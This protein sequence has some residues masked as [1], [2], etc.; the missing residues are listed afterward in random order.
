M[1]K[2]ILITGS[3]S[4]LGRAA[5][6]LFHRNGW[7]VIATMRTP[8]QETELNRLEHVLVTRLDVEDAPS[9]RSAIDA[10]LARFGG[11]D[12]LLNNAG[13]GQ[14]GPLEAIPINMIRRQFEVNLIGLL[15]T[16]QSILPHFRARASGTIINI[17]S[18]GGRMA[19]P[20]GSL[21]NGSKFAVEGISEALQ[22]EL[23]PLGVSVKIVE[24]GAIDTDF[25]GRSMSFTNDRTMDEYQPLIQSAMGAY[26]A[27]MKGGAQPDAIAETIFLAATDGK[28]TLRYVAGADGVAISARRAALDDTEFFK[29]IKSQFGLNA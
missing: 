10:G 3:S 9:M 7:N 4:G 13:F 5:A 17:T 19:F 22:Y 20:F 21:Y 14:F 27:M 29:G 24:P 1:S 28:A 2:T 8:S 18:I 16:T 6:K 23:A 25:A 12:V 26:G 15:Q 11:I